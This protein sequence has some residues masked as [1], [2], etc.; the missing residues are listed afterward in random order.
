MRL[1]QAITAWA[2]SNK[3]VDI[4]EHLRIAGFYGSLAT[5]GFELSYM[6][7]WV[8]NLKGNRSYLVQSSPTFKTFGVGFNIN[9][10]N[11]IDAHLV[12]KN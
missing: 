10:K 1:S 6:K 7:D 8:E 3:S 5:S 11:M 12:F 4:F 2:K 9:E